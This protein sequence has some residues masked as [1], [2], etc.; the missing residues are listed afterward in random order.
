MSDLEFATPNNNIENI[1]KIIMC[2]IYVAII[3]FVSDHQTHN[4]QCIIK[5]ILYEP[6][7]FDHIF[8]NI[9]KY[10][11]IRVGWMGRSASTMRKTK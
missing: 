5:N 3:F 9:L 8:S 6:P 10:L 11:P 2:S 1:I 7:T 4:V